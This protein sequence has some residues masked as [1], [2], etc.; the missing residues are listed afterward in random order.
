MCTPNNT[1]PNPTLCF[2]L[3]LKECSELVNETDSVEITCQRGFNVNRGNRRV[4]HPDII[5]MGEFLSGSNEEC[6]RI[7]KFYW[8]HQKIKSCPN[9]KQCGF[10]IAVT[11]IHGRG[12]DDFDIGLSTDVEDYNEDIH[13]HSEVMSSNN[14]HFVL[15]REFRSGDSYNLYV[16]W[17]GKP[18]YPS[19]FENHIEWKESIASAGYITPIVYYDSSESD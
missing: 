4:V 3:L 7:Y 17:A 6:R 1:R 19:Q 13:F 12:S 2:K 16:S 14:M 18:I 5:R 9:P 15:R 11:P 8:K 10:V